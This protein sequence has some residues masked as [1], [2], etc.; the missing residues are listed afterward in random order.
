MNDI[1]VPNHGKKKFK[2]NRKKVRK[3]V[4]KEIESA[5]VQKVEAEAED[6]AESVDSGCIPDSSSDLLTD[7]NDPAQVSSGVE[8]VCCVTVAFCSVVVWQ[9]VVLLVSVKCTT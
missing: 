6:A 7:P 2:N 4:T 9:H 8:Q 3:N 1:I 5:A